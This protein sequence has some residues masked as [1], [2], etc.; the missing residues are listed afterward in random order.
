M[1]EYALLINL[2]QLVYIMYINTFYVRANPLHEAA[3]I[4]NNTATGDKVS[5]NGYAENSI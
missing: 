1:Q 2:L 3:I 4:A 5:E